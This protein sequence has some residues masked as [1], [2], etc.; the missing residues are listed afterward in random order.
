MP[1]KNILVDDEEGILV[2]QDSRG[3]EIYQ[4]F[5][6]RSPGIVDI[7][8]GGDGSSLSSRLYVRYDVF[9][10][11][12][13]IKRTFNYTDEDLRIATNILHTLGAEHPADAFKI[14]WRKIKERSA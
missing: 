7:L 10:R 4:V 5:M 6:F 1:W 12:I 14:C 13:D 11:Q 9:G 3:F 8:L 2:Q